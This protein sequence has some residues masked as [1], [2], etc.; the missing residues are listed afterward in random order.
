MRN[1][2][3]LIAAFWVGVPFLSLGQSQTDLPHFFPPGIIQAGSAAEQWE[4]YLRYIMAT[5]HCQG[6]LGDKGRFISGGDAVRR[7]VKINGKDMTVILDPYVKNKDGTI[8]FTSYCGQEKVTEAQLNTVVAYL[9]KQET[10]AE[11]LNWLFYNDVETLIVRERAKKLGVKE[12]DFVAGLDKPSRYPDITVREEHLLPPK[13]E[14]S[15]FVPKELHLG[16]FPEMVGSGVLGAAWLNSGTNYVTMQALVLDYLAGKPVVMMHENIHA[17][18]KLQ[19]LPLSEGFNVEL[20]ASIPEMLLDD[21]HIQ[22][23]FHHYLEPIRELFWIHFGFDFKQAQKEI[24][25][26]DL[27]GNIFV[28]KDK[29]NKYTGLLDKA[30]PL[31]RETLKKA[32]VEFYSDA[33]GWVAL[34]DKLQNSNGVLDVMFAKN[35]DLCVQVTDKADCN[36]TMKW[37]KANEE[38]IKKIAEESFKESG[39]PAA[40]GGPSAMGQQMTRYEPMLGVLKTIYPQIKEKELTAFLSKEGFSPSDLLKMDNIK[41]MGLFKKFLATQEGRR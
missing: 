32:L 21:D 29:F 39:T 33:P 7:V 22:L 9:T 23:W 27:A 19:S 1:R 24:V 10:I 6:V 28:D 5:E 4:T 18:P 15:D 3:F 17:N 41:L 12:S 31:A 20:F 13:F 40:T 38:R 30:K 37:L 11:D 25:R 8:V 34:H 36:A 26:A 2:L 16:Y 35:F 14:K